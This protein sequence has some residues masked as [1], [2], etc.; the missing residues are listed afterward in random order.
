ML[1]LFGERGLVGMQPRLPSFRAAARPLID[2]YLARAEKLTA[3][4]RAA[5]DL[6]EKSFA[7]RPLSDSALESFVF[8][9]EDGVRRKLLPVEARALRRDAILSPS[10][11]LRPALQDYVLPT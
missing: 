9:I 5:G 8:A 7:R 10:V 2:R 1:A 11:A 6:L 4:A 3:A